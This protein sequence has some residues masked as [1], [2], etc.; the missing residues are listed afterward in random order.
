MEYASTA[1]SWRS[2]L[3]ARRQR[4]R[5][6][7]RRTLVVVGNGMVS[8]RFCER[9]VSLGAHRTHRVIVFG[10]EPRVA[11]DRVHLSSYVTHRDE[12]RLV[13]KDERWYTERDI[14][15]HLGDPVESLQLERREA[16]ARSGAK[17]RWDLLVLATGS[18]PFV[19]PIEGAGLDGVFVY[20]TVD[21]LRALLAYA[22]GGQEAAVIGGGLL[23]LEAAQAVQN[24]GLDA[25]VVEVADFLLPQQLDA[26]AGEVLLVQ[27]E[28]QGVRVHLGR[29]TERI[30]P[31][32]RRRHL[33]FADGGSLGVD[34][35]IISAGVRP[36]T[37]LARAAGLPVAGNG[38][39]V[40]DEQLQVQDGVFAI[41]DCASFHGRTYGLV[42]PGY[43]MADVLAERIATRAR[44]AF[45][46]ADTSTRLKMLGVDVTTLGDHLEPGQSLVSQGDDYV[47][48]LVL[49][50]GRPVGA[51]GVGDWPEAGALQMAI[52]R[53]QRVSRRMRH[54]FVEEGRLWSE[55]P[56]VSSW[57]DET[58][59][60]NC[61][62]VTKKELCSALAA[63]ATDA[64][65]LTQVTGAGAVC[66]SCRPLVAELAGSIADAD[67]G[68][69]AATL[70]W[71]S[72][73]A[74]LVAVLALALPPMPVASSVDVFWH[75]LELLWSDSLWK[76]VSG[77]SIA[78]LTLLGLT[79][80]IRKRW[81]WVR[82]GAIPA[83]R[84]LH[85][86]LGL[87]TLL[88]LFA[89]TGYRFGHNLNLALMS[90]FVAMSII[91]AVA[92][93]TCATEARTFGRSAVL[94]RRWRPTVTRLHLLATWPVPV[95]IL[96]HILAV[97][98]F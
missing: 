96:F 55:V 2:R 20:R 41:G 53:R 52:A 16:T 49:E 42:S 98:Y 80:S 7:E 78:T 18:S 15:L 13:L 58:L 97:Y 37:E 26:R 38:G 47:R 14:D 70:L 48:T 63:G 28:R 61:Q 71:A 44:R 50:R 81:S 25:H 33:C 60:C 36:R 1:Q 46:G 93:V 22:S 57:S 76:Q 75:R 65:R 39:V 6:S 73:F 23:G 51:F 84:N 43:Q 62:G 79:L 89:H 31:E 56:G 32:G 67:A 21:D 77:F 4:A 88:G 92:G 10:E 11:Y 66:G 54:R 5:S 68:A 82:I 64:A 19:P 87:G 24:L 27:V 9:L 8:A 34:M 69:G 91:G 29:R 83:W 94:A 74:L 85:A 59:V 40:V 35:V 90:S 3:T 86:I 45:R 30:R 72:G 12:R 95:L 17:V